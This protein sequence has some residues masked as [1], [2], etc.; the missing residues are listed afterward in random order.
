[1]Y[2]AVRSGIFTKEKNHNLPEIVEVPGARICVSQQLITALQH[3]TSRQSDCDPFEHLLEA[4][5]MT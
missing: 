3:P 4:Q 5:S 1:V 2:F